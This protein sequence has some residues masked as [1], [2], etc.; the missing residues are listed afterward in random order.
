M[1]SAGFVAVKGVDGHKFSDFKEIR[2]AK[3][4]FEF[5]IE[6]SLL[7]CHID[8][9]PEL[10]LEVPDHLDTLFQ[11]SLIAGHT[12]VLPHYVTEFLMDGVH[13]FGTFDGKQTL[14]LLSDSLFS[15]VKL[16]G[17]DICLRLL[18]L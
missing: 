2:K 7:S 9:A 5:L 17:S 14:N 8:I 16:R 4:F 6:G 15:L 13:G 18:E 11:T 1:T 12:D 10:R 3:S